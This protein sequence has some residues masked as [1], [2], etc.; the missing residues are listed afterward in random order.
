MGVILLLL[1]F[2]FRSGVW[3]YVVDFINRYERPAGESK[4]HSEVSR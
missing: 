3:G 2:K 1:V 4:S